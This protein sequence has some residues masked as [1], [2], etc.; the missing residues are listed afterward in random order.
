[1]FT[2]VIWDGAQC[3]KKVSSHVWRMI[4]MDQETNLSNQVISDGGLGL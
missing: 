3:N 1:V 4:A 2:F